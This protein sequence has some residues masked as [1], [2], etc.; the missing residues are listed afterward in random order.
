M[1]KCITVISAL[2]VLGVLGGE[3]EAQALSSEM[4]MGRWC[5]N[6]G[7]YFFTPNRATITLSNGNQ[8]VLHIRSIRIEGP[9]IIVTWQEDANIRVQANRGKGSE[10]TFT[11]FT[12]GSLVQSSMKLP[13]GTSSPNRPFHRC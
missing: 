8:H 1:G 12:G 13:D 3:S 2:A 4:L 10:T 6:G 5:S 9:N 7:S 11:Q